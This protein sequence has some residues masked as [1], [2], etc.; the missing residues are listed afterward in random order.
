MS[1]FS[2]DWLALREPADARARS[3]ALAARFAAGVQRAADLATGTGANIRYLAPRLGGATEWLAVDDDP[4]LLAAHVAPA[5]TSV[6]T[7]RLDLARSLEAVPLLG[8]DL[9]SAS[10]LLDLVS[11]G[12]LD[13]LVAACA[14]ARAAVLFALTYDGRI[15]WSPSDA[16]DARV[17]ELVNRHQRRD[18]G[19]GPA[20]GPGAAAAA[21][22]RFAARG[23]G[24]ER[25]RSDWVLGPTDARLQQALVD[26]WLAAALEVAPA[27][28][29]ALTAWAERRRELAVRGAATLTVGHQDLAGW[30]L[31]TG[32][33]R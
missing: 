23:Y 6:R 7:L 29:A 8:C 19:F 21:A 33:P 16:A 2:A 25:A 9:V 5:G 4:A 30:P 28:R 17:R 22:A 31:H 15:E 11:A 1:G 3:A 32:A 26:G 14:R 13:R 18:K 10:A 24:V 27:E 12:W 20:L